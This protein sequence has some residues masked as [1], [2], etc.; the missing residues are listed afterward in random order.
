MKKIIIIFIIFLWFSCNFDK[1]N[2]IDNEN[3]L[4]KNI[5][6]NI[7]T[8][9]L[10]KSKNI[11]EKVEK[12]D[13]N[14]ETEIILE[15][16]NINDK[17]KKL[18]E[19]RENLIKYEKIHWP[20]LELHTSTWFY[21]T[22][23]KEMYKY[24]IKD[25]TIKLK[26]DDKAKK[27]IVVN[28]KNKAKLDCFLWLWDYKWV[29]LVGLNMDFIKNFWNLI[30]N[31]FENLEIDIK[32][33]EIIDDLFLSLLNKNITNLKFN[34]SWIN[35]DI[36]YKIDKKITDKILSTNNNIE[37]NLRLYKNLKFEDNDFLEKIKNKKNIKLTLNK[38]KKG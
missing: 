20:Y 12:I 36:V 21:E 37:L 8:N 11:T 4:N 1:E 17:S 28:E 5:E 10:C 2:K 9:V 14:G 29:S 16:K 26:Y 18:L 3:I 13:E 25:K 19:N 24:S 31:N 35:N 33:S 22:N 7:D 38:I 34:I 32:E 6:K 15:E 30:P 27:H 23:Y